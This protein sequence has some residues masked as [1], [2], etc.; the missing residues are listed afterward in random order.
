MD[1]EIAYGGVWY[2]VFGV[3]GIGYSCIHEKQNSFTHAPSLVVPSLVSCDLPFLLVNLL[4]KS[5]SRLVNRIIL[6][7]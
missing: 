2:L 3:L 6:L 7:D 5:R 4:Q 1:G